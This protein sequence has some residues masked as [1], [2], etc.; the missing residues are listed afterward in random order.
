MVGHKVSII[1]PFYNPGESFKKC[2][3]SVINQSLEDVEVIFVNDGST[4]N[5][6]DIIKENMS[7]G[8]FKLINQDNLGA[9]V[10]RNNAI[11]EATGEYI[12]FLDSD[13]WIEP[14]ACEELYNHAKRLNSD[15]VLFDVLWYI[16]KNKIKKISYF[17]NNSN[18][19]FADFTFSCDFVKDKMMRGIYGVIWSKFYKTSFIKK[20][21]IK[22]PSHKIYNDIEFHFKTMLLA[23]EISYI[24]KIFYNYSYINKPSLQKSFKGSKYELCWFNVIMGIRK[25]LNENMLFEDYKEDFLKFFIYYSQIK[26]NE[27]HEDYKQKLFIKIKYFFESADLNFN[28]FEHIP[29]S[30]SVFYFHIINSDNYSEFKFMQDN[31]DGSTIK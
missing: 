16:K 12:L 28:D 21:N 29:F 13:D 8:S 5:S 17:S 20:N 2:L 18:I 22:F 24:P 14:V 9:G 30:Y 31:F 10:A 25:F 15:L 3:S 11:E 6:M 19:D 27:V 1:I 7:N 4:D 23:K 26:L